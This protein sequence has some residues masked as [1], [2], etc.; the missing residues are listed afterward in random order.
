M[1]TDKHSRC[2]KQLF[3]LNPTL[4]WL[5]KLHVRAESADS[6]CNQPHACLCQFRQVDYRNLCSCFKSICKICFTHTCLLIYQ[7]K[8]YS[9]HLLLRAKLIQQCHTDCT[10]ACI[11]SC[12]I[13]CSG[14]PLTICLIITHMVIVHPN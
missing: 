13:T 12:I 2:I 6:C 8:V 11:T 10:I 9:Q 4:I 1:Q 14:S 5:Y 7:D 3:R